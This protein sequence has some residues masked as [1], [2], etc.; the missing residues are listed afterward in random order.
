MPH[1]PSA[2]I[3]DLGAVCEDSFV[4]ED[5]WVVFWNGSKRGVHHHICN[6]PKQ[7]P[8]AVYSFP[9]SPPL[10]LLL[11]LL[12]LFDFSCSLEITHKNFSDPLLLL[13]I[14]PSKI[15]SLVARGVK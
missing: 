6:G 1:S 8:P 3:Y 9:V 7:T 11:L 10:L 2:V 12:L 15:F 14:F 4:L 13:L 5:F